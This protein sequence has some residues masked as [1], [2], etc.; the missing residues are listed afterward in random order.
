MAWWD[1]PQ[2]PYELQAAD[3]VVGQRF[4]QFDTGGDFDVDGIPG[5]SVHD[6]Y[7]FLNT[8]LGGDAANFGKPGYEMGTQ[9]LTTPRVAPQQT[10]SPYQMVNLPD[11]TRYYGNQQNAQQQAFRQNNP[12][13]QAKVPVGQSQRMLEQQA[14]TPPPAYRPYQG[15]SLRGTPTKTGSLGGY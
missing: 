1:A 15:Y 4:S 3:T 11:G 2:T 9:Y 12:V 14:V 13:T 6:Y 10:T 8:Y 5:V 7:T